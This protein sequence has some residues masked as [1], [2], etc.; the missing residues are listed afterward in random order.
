MQ[1]ADHAGLA[2]GRIDQFVYVM[3]AVEVSTQGSVGLHYSVII[4]SPEQQ[5]ATMDFFE[6]SHRFRNQVN[7]VRVIQ[8]MCSLTLQCAM[9]SLIACTMGD[10]LRK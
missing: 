1:L 7:I 5:R 8:G 3:Q 4:I 9:W 2:V 6:L 10:T